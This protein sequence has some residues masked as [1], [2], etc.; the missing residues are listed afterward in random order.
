[1]EGE[2]FNVYLIACGGIG[3]KEALRRVREIGIKATRATSAYVGQTAVLVFTH[4]QR[5]LHRISRLLYGR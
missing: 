3:Q 4:N 5:K 2:I 1:M